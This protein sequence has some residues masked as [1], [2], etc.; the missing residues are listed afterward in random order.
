[1]HAHAEPRHTA[2]KIKVAK[3]SVYTPAAHWR[4]AYLVAC[5]RPTLLNL[6]PLDPK[7]GQLHWHAISRVKRTIRRI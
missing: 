4:A 6:P 2:D 7:A 3:K 5:A 1:M